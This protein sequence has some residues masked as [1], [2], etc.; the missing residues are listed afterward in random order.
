MNNVKFTYNSC[1]KALLLVV[2]MYLMTSC[3]TSNRNTYRLLNAEYLF[4][5]DSLKAL[6]IIRSIPSTAFSE[7]LFYIVHDQNCIINVICYQIAYQIEKGDFY[8]AELLVRSLLKTIVQSDSFDFSTRKG[9]YSSEKIVQSLFE[10]QKLLIKAEALPNLDKYKKEELNDILKRQFNIVHPYT[11]FH[12]YGPTGFVLERRFL[13]SPYYLLSIILVSTILL[14]LVF[15]NKRLEMH[16]THVRKL[17]EHESF[18]NNK[19]VDLNLQIN[20]LSVDLKD[21]EK[22]TIRLHE[23]VYESLGTGKKI[24]EMIKEGKCIQDISSLEEQSFIDY[25][26]FTYPEDYHKITEAYVSLAIRHKLYLILSYMGYD[27]MRIQKILKIKG[28]TIRNY[29]LRIKKRLKHSYIAS[30]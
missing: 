2:M 7:P 17:K 21:K 25:Y 16:K 4:E 22:Q 13:E 28:C 15:Y 10:F 14:L 8:Q 11:H 24:Y 1:F 20:D 12:C 9:N 6:S 5:D 19:I 26:S 3:T 29:R 23:N 27:D 18:Y 30:H